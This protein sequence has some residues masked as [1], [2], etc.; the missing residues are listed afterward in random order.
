MDNS[1]GN[2]CLTMWTLKTLK[3]SGAVEKNLGF[4]KSPSSDFIWRGTTSSLAV[5]RFAG[6]KGS[7]YSP[8]GRIVASLRKT[9]PVK[10]E[11]SQKEGLVFRLKRKDYKS[12]RDITKPC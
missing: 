5:G 6:K 12:E 3:D 11:R 8:R 10:S 9:L 4:Q 2:E 7:P 1:G